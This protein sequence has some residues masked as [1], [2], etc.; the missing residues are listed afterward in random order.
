MNVLQTQDDVIVL[1]MTRFNK[2]N[3]DIEGVIP[4]IKRRV[5]VPDN[6]DTLQVP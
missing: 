4:Q 1:N 2:A 6:E 3:A 5:Y